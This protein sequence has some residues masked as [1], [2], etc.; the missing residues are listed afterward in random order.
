MM[1]KADSCILVTGGA[2]YIGSHTIIELFRSGVETVISID[3]YANSSAKSY[4]R[5]EAISGKKTIYYDIDLTHL[6]DVENV[7]KK[8]PNIVGVI[9]FAAL[10]AVGESVQK[11]LSYYRNNL[12]S[13]LN[14]LELSARYG[15]KSFIFSSSCT[16]Y[17]EPKEFPVNE[18]TPL[19]E[20]ESPYGYT[21]SVG[22]RII[23]DFSLNQHDM[24]FVLLRYFNPVGAHPSGKIGEPQEQKPNN[25]MP[26]ITMTAAGLL[27]QLTVHGG[28][29]PTRDGTCIRDY[30]HVCDIAEAHVKALEY[31]ATD[32]V[33]KQI[34]IFNL[35]SGNG[36]SVLEAINTFE[37]VAGLK[38]NYVI[39]P[40]RPGDIIAIYSDSSKAEKVLGWMPKYTIED[41]M[42]S[43]WKWQE[44][45]VSEKK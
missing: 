7:F 28:D 26:F 10:K 1:N 44:N 35:G 24:K 9:H 38:L 12:V 21:K 33:D 8:H 16:V 32:M 37:K 14:V 45:I 31:S 18:S 29:Y 2:G 42:S 13:L 3:D 39:G 43:A 11:S 20:P 22:E 17:G 30:V 25:L 19:L 41:M 15:V 34:D 23:K 40:R 6:N 5:I 4:E 36:V 27:P